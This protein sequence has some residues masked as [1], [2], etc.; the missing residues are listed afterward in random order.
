MI[1]IQGRIQRAAESILDNEA[2]T[3]ELDDEAAKVLLDWGL[4]LARQIAGQTIEMDEAQAEEAMYQPMRSLRKMLRGANRWANGPGEKNLRRVL[5]EAP[6]VYGA[7]YRQPDEQRVD[8]FMGRVAP[9]APERVMAL[10]SFL[11]GKPDDPPRGR[12]V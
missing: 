12:R 6:I 4:G 11:E 3:S 5:K 1:E 9:S 10:R 2:L 8:T 7:G